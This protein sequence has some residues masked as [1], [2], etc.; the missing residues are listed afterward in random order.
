MFKTA[1]AFV[2][3]R[4]LRRIAILNVPH[5]VRAEWLRGV[6]LRFFWRV[7]IPQHLAVEGDFSD[8]ELMGEKDFAAW[9]QHRITD[10][11]S[12]GMRV[13]PHHLSVMHNE[14]F[15]SLPF[16]SVEKIMLCKSFARKNQWQS[17]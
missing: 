3:D 10:F 16:P 8:A 6:Y 15:L 17:I 2:D 7:Q 5:T 9:F 1:G 11:P 12:T 14:H 13:R 4:E